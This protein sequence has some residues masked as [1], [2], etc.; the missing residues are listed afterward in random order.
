MAS[1]I[2]LAVGRFEVDWGRNTI[3]RDHSPLFQAEA[4]VVPVPHYYFDGSQ[5]KV[6]V[7]YKDGLAKSIPAVL[8]RLDLL[9]HTR[10][11]C[12][13]EFDAVAESHRLDTA[14]FDHERLRTAL[15]SVDVTSV[16]ADYAEGGVGK[17]FRREIAPRLQLE[18]PVDRDGFDASVAMDALSPYA[19]LRL[20][21]DNPNASGLP[22][23]WAFADAIEDGYAER[24]DFVR[25]LE[26]AHRFLVVTEGS[27]D[28]KILRQAFGLLRPH[29]ADFFDFVDMGDGYPFTGTG[30]MYRFVQGLIGISVQNKVVVVFDN[31]AAGSATCERCRLLGVLPN[32]RI[33][34]LPDLPAFRG[35]PTVGPQ[36]EHAAD[37]NGRAA[38]IECYLDIGSEARVR[39]TSY[40]ASVGVYQGALEAK[41]RYARE[42]LR[43]RNREAG[44]DY[45]RI[46][47]VLASIVD[48]AI[49][50]AEQTGRHGLPFA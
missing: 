14:R 50:I 43:Q 41:E 6:T 9:G 3:Y 26:A 37:I 48:S 36:G 21:A 49:A 10:E 32:M 8:E 13:R 1:M 45:S 28:A 27:S 47:A 16:S 4:D 42:F 31:D 5:E 46:D 12:E 22:V 23:G 17:F 11:A 33:V 34:K 25:P 19:V 39:W 35:F 18:P 30:N 20:L 40:E 7:E 2:D 29:V 24:A 15:A 44:Y 38:A